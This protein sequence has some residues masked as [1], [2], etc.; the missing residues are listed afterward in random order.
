MEVQ[1]DKGSK[2]KPR[3]IDYKHS[4]YKKRWFKHNVDIDSHGI[5]DMDYNDDV[6][7]NA[8]WN[9]EEPL[10]PEEYNM[11]LELNE[12]KLMYVKAERE[13]IHFCAEKYRAYNQQVVNDFKHRCL[14]LVAIYS[15]EVIFSIL[16][17]TGFDPVT[18]FGVDAIPTDGLHEKMN[19]RN[20]SNGN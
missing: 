15:E 16:K 4:Q 9:E 17:P 1:D 12:L 5:E 13:S 11:A 3:I 8:V 20:S 18:Y 19:K 10:S 7:N 6:D 14:E 2:K